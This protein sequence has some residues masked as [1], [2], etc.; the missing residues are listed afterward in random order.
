MNAGDN[1]LVALLDQLPTT[2]LANADEVLAN[3]EGPVAA[4]FSAY[5]SSGDPEALERTLDAHFGLSGPDRPGNVS[6]FLDAAKDL[7]TLGGPFAL[8]GP[9]EALRRQRRVLD[10]TTASGC[11]IYPGKPFPGLFLGK[12]NSYT[13]ALWLIHG[14]ASE[15]APGGYV[16]TMP[17][18]DLTDWAV[19][20]RDRHDHG[21]A[22]HDDRAEFLG[23]LAVWALRLDELL[24]IQ[25]ALHDVAP[26]GTAATVDLARGRLQPI[27]GD[28]VEQI[29]AW[30]QLAFLRPWVTV[31]ERD[32]APAPTGPPRR[33]SAIDPATPQHLVR[34]GALCGN[35]MFGV[36][37]GLAPATSTAALA[38]LIQQDPE[39]VRLATTAGHA[40]MTVL[41]T[42]ALPIPN[43]L[44][45][46]VHTQVGLAI[47]KDVDA[48]REAL[49]KWTKRS[50][51]HLQKNGHDSFVAAGAALGRLVLDADPSQLATVL[52][53]ITALLGE[54]GELEVLEAIT[55]ACIGGCYDD[56]MATAKLD[57]PS[58][59]TAKK[60][61]RAARVFNVRMVHAMVA[62]GTPLD[63]PA[64]WA[65]AVRGAQ[66]LKAKA[67]D[68]PRQLLDELTKLG[69]GPDATKPQAPTVPRRDDVA[70]LERLESEAGF[71]WALPVVASERASP[72][73]VV[74]TL[75]LDC[76]LAWWTEK[77]PRAL[78]EQMEAWTVGERFRIQLSFAQRKDGELV[79][80]LWVDPDNALPGALMAHVVLA[81]V[82]S[83]AFALHDVL[84]VEGW[85]LARPDA[86]RRE[87]Q[88][89]AGK[90]FL[91]GD[92]VGVLDPTGV[93][94]Q[95][96]EIGHDRMT[97]L[98]VALMARATHARKTACA[99]W[100][101]TA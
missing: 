63:D 2:P 24:A 3:A 65:A 21:R 14:I 5:L 23:A 89:R 83:A 98:P 53:E 56:V 79:L 11:A 85:G 39:P 60:L 64:L 72:A 67:S 59:R 69:V 8:W 20:L 78:R 94:W 35:R 99:C 50:E 16:L 27:L 62:L 52:S 51:A 81:T 45:G 42:Q 54:W 13:H 37:T 47:S 17:N 9:I 36:M 12:L 61:A 97:R 18:Q 87:A 1:P 57:K 90:L 93:H 71:V 70:R 74:H 41:W 38:R 15:S 68:N 96:P 55:K 34:L 26:D 86:S 40:A 100:I 25:V 4:V 48:V 73:P 10:F 84:Q 80:A 31:R 44:P 92:R 33:L 28:R 6:W 66:T 19:E 101:C 22:H 95:L 58:G 76:L 91:H 77:L 7:A 46:R 32:E 30:K 29:G 49:E 82:G 88:Q 43:E 75:L